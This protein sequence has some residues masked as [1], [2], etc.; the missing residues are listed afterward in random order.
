MTM[1][2]VTLP[3]RA[4]AYGVAMLSTG[5]TLLFRWLLENLIGRHAEL[6]TFFPAIIL[7]AYFGGLGPGLLAMLLGA[8]S[9][10]YFFG[11]PRYSLAIHDVGEAYG[12]GL[13]LLAGAFISGL[14]E[15]MHRSRRRILGTYV[16]IAELK[17]AE[18]AVRESEQRWRNL[19]EALPQ[20]VWSATPDGACDYFSGQW[21]AHTGIAEPDLL[22][23]RWLA[24]LHPDDREPTRQFWLESVA[25]RHPYDIEY[26]VCRRDGQY[27]WFKTRGTPIRDESG[28]IIKWFGSCTDIT[29]LRQAEHAL[30]A[31]ERRFRGTFENAAVG[32][33][34]CDVNGRFLDVNETYCAIVGYSLDELFQ[35]TFHDI[36]HPDDLAANVAN[37]SALMRGERPAFAMEKRYLRKDGSI[38]WVELFISLQRDEADHPAYSIG[39]VQDITER[40][41]LDRE[42]RQAKEVAEAANRAKDEFLANVSHEIRT[43]MNAILGMTELV[44]E[45]ELTGGQRE[46]L[47]TAKSAADNLLGI[48]NDLLDFAKIEAGKLELDPADFSLRAVVEDTVRALDVRAH[49]KGLGLSWTVQPDVPDALLGDAGRLRQVLLNLVG[50]AIKFTDKGEVVIRVEIA[51]DSPRYEAERTCLRFIVSDTG[52]G[53]PPEKRER[54][55][56][57]FEQEDTSTTRKYGGTGLGLTIAA[58]LVE[59]MEGEITVDSEPGRGST[60][61]FEANFGRQPKAAEHRAARPRGPMLLDRQTLSILAA[62]DDEF[63]GQLLE[64]L[65]TR[66]GHKVRLATKGTEALRLAKEGGFDVMLLDVHMPEMDGFQVVQAIRASELATGGHLPIIALTARSRKE[67]REKCLAAGM[68]DFLTKPIA[69]ANLWAAIERVVPPHERG[70]FQELGLLDPEVLLS[71]CGGDASLLENLCRALKLQ[72]PDRIR[73]VKDALR[74]GEAPRLR[75]A[76]HKL[77]GMVA[78]FSR[79]AGTL[80]SELED[81]AACGQLDEARLLV[82]QLDTMAIELIGSVDGLSLGALAAGRSQPTPHSQRD[83]SP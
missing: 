56:R 60:F 47:S 48:I 50:N 69:A 11:E 7:S 19:T 72:L 61:T 22:G 25:E 52:I 14:M 36:T 63:S 40:K 21:T 81:R 77:C 18:E 43:P 29:D 33:V 71:A 49:K 31:S 27:R 65:L 45:G 75:E 13:F 24:T 44:L 62:E 16:E 59:L 17:K 78:A 57:A 76:A 41:Q 38:V 9:G 20:L 4:V 55:F 82:A 26:R 35:K 8:L 42:L 2:R 1:S 34:H 54:I 83:I 6:M 10:A 12:L 53:I 32:I 23:W 28:N 74:Q 51:L 37:Y 68:D 3:N 80:A 66:R 46:C 30:R 64:Q 70:E 15:T 79:S 67:D 73:A 58:Q 39:I 5:I